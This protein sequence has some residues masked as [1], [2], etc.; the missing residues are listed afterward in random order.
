[1]KSVLIESQFLPP[2]SYFALLTHY[3]EIII[4]RWEH[5]VKQSYRNR[6]YINTPSGKGMVVIPLTAKHGKP[7]ITDVKID[8]N[9]K[10]LNGLWRTIQSAYGNAPFFDYYAEDFHA[11]LFRKISFLYELNQELLSL[12]LKCLR[13]NTPVK[14]SQRYKEEILPPIYDRRNVI[15]NKSKIHDPDLYRPVAYPQVFG[16]KFVPDLSVLDLI[17]CMGPDASMIIQRS[18]GT[19]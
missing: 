5:F 10:W 6:F 3:N 7:F 9:Q 2:L 16:S 4:E 1:M 15:R 18:A 11:I 12:C 19:K 13:W 8:Y 14:E 17:Y